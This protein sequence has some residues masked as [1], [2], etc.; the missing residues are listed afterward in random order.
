MIEKKAPMRAPS[1]PAALR[2]VLM[3]GAKDAQMS[4][5][6]AAPLI[7]SPDLNALTAAMTLLVISGA[8]LAMAS[9]RFLASSRSF[10]DLSASTSSLRACSYSFLTPSIF[11]DHRM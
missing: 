10:L 8:A 1:G 2:K 7:G 4:M 3:S 9:P 6:A 5:S 11:I